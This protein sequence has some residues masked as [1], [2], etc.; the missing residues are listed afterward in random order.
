[1]PPEAETALFVGLNILGV[2]LRVFWP[3][4]LAYLQDGASFDPKFVIGQLLAALI[5]LFGVMAAKDF[6]AELGTVGYFG[7]LVAGYGAA[8]IGRDGQKT[9]GRIRG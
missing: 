6:A 4:F 1:M 2:A 7:A 5:A 8:S 3:Y 9:A